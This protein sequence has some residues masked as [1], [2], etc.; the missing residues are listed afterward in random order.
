MKT[1][2]KANRKAA[3]PATPAIPSPE[4][5]NAQFVSRLKDAVPDLFSIRGVQMRKRFWRSAEGPRVYAY[6]VYPQDTS[7]IVREDSNGKK[8]LGKL[9]KGRFLTVRRK[10][11]P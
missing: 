2:T 11:A 5:V 3:T 1:D 8:Q 7:L 9:V 6:S 10:I 4:L